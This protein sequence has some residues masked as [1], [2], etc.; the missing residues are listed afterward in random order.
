M[1]LSIM[2]APNYGL[3]FLYLPFLLSQQKMPSWNAGEEGEE[4]FP[5][6]SWQKN[7][8]FKHNATYNFFQVSS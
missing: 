5:S 6:Y 4:V 3:E 8:S 2:L 7:E 1:S